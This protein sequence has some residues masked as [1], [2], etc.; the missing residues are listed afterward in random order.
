MATLH[1]LLALC[2][3]ENPDILMQKAKVQIALWEKWLN[4]VSSDNAT[5]EDPGYDD[6]FQRMREEVNKL[7]GADTELVCQLAE[8]LLTTVCKDVRVATYYLWARLHRDGESGLAEGL[9]LLSGLVSR[10]GDQLLPSRKN[11][12][13]AAMEWLAGSKVLD[14]LSLY[15]EVDK[16]KFERIL[17]ALTLFED[18]ITSWEDANQPQLG[19]LYD[20]L[21]SRLAQSGGFDAV[22][23]QN[24][25]GQATSDSRSIS[26]DMPSLKVIQSGRELLDQ[27]KA[28]AQ[29]LRDQPQGWLS[30]HRLMTTIRWDTVDQLPPLDAKGCTR[31]VPPRTDYR[32]QLKRLYLQ[33]SWSELLENADRMFTEGVN[34]FWLD[35]QWYLHQALSKSGAPYDSW[36]EFIEQD[37]RLLLLRLPGIETLAYS[38][39]TPFA[40][41]VTAGWIARDI[42]DNDGRWQS[43]PNA[44]SASGDEDVLQLETE[45]LAQADSEGIEAALNWLQIRPGITTPRQRWL[46]RLLMARVAEQY[47]KNEMALHLLGELDSTGNSLTLK[48]WEPALLFEVKARRLKLLRMQFQRG[49]TDKAKLILEMDTLLAGLVSIDPARAAVLCA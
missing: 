34:H 44:V 24:S 12:R 32:A 35:I 22:V 37:L 5:G 20:A 27:A 31:L 33:Q 9:E 13:R 23:P 38:D 3:Q 25:G 1:T 29:Y 45:A 49:D 26:P 10:Y 39:G 47:G 2:P 40:D 4:P 8:K 19:G 18:V 41:E 6:D 46:I 11:S 7:S 16:P 21:E 15:P 28:L 42:Q 14:S 17:A 48:Q 30:G 43:E 36:A